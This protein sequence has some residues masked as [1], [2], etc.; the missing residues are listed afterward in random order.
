MGRQVRRVPREWEHPTDED[1]DF[2]PLY[3]QSFADDLRDWSEA[4]LQW[5][6]G[7]V[8]DYGLDGFDRWEPKPASALACESFEEWHGEKPDPMSYMP[9]F[10]ESDRTHW[11]MYENVTE[12]TP[13]SPVMDS[14]EDLAQWLADNRASAFAGQTATRDQWLAT[15]NAGSAPSA[16][17]LPGKGLISGVEAMSEDR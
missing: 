7:F 11:Q 13:I 14:A 3:D 1:G 12:G 16:V 17:S 15:I 8:R 2:I 10:P 4:R 5:E 9:W 6:R